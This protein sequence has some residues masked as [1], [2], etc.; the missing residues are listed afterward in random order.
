M[1]GFSLLWWAGATLHCGMW[2]LHCSGFSCCRAPE[3]AVLIL[4][5][6]SCPTLCK[7]MDCS[8]LGFSVY[9]ILQARILE[10]IA[11][12]SSRGSSQL[13][14][15]AHIC[16]CLLALE[17]GFF[18]TD[19]I[20]VVADADSVVTAHGLSHSAACGIFP[21][22]RLNPSPLHWEVDSTTGPLVVQLLSHVWLC[23]RMAG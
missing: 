3:W 12:P 11:V 4:V 9:G 16:C 23:N 8:P 20:Y 1:P 10:W 15:G 19:A 6:Q 14:D 13:R 2:A 21:D 5:T 22:Q 18:T 17:G 7:L